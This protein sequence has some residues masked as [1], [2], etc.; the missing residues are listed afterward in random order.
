MY[1]SSVYHYIKQIELCDRQ[2]DSRVYYEYCPPP[3]APH[4][5]EE[6]RDLVDAVC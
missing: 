6:R 3:L 5:V 1:I 4:S 2:P